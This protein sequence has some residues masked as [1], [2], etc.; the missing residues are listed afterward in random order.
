MLDAKRLKGDSSSNTSDKE[1]VFPNLR[2]SLAHAFT[3][4]M[5]QSTIE[6]KAL[7]PRTQLRL[8]QQEIDNKCVPLN[9]AKTKDGENMNDETLNDDRLRKDKV[10]F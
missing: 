4:S 2:K 7:S 10:Y 6:R 1:V 8:K 5:R 3:K 9:Q